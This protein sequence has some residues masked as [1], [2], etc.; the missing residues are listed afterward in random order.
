MV[1]IGDR[2]IIANFAALGIVQGSNFLIPLIV[3]P[4]VIAR[5][6]AEGLGEIAIAQVIITFFITISDYGFNL[7]ATREVALN[8]ENVPLISRLFFSVLFCKLLISALLFIVLLIA[9]LSIPFLRPYTALYMLSFTSVIGQV[10]LVNWLFQAIE[11]MK[12]ITYITLF[13]RIIFLLLVVFFI[14]TRTDNIYFIFFTGVSNIVAGLLSMVVA[15]RLLKL[16]F[17]VPTAAALRLEFKNGWH[18][19]LSNLSISTYMYINVLVLR[20]VTNDRMVGF[21]SIAEKIIL[22]ARQVLSVYFQV[23]YPQVC[24]LAVKSKQELYFFLKRNYLF[25]LVSMLL[26]GFFLL[27]LAEPIIGFFLKVDQ[28]IPAEYLRIMC[29]VP[30]IVCLNIPAYQVLL[31][32]NKKEA[33][34]KVFIVGTI[35]NIVLNLSLVPVWGAIGTSYVVLITEAFITL[36]LI[37]FMNR[38]PKTKTLK[39]IM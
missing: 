34:M 7:T 35:L 20:L 28:A 25:F 27:F 2:R 11:R 14:K 18:I 1:K 31:A 6:G 10:V 17:V 21:Y 32:F 4:F 36:S 37:V 8:K 38:D 12:F 23:V 9:V 13:A 16:Q 3:M 22:A 24:Q 29:F 39:Y 26:G 5:I 15:F 33:L 19:M 30:F